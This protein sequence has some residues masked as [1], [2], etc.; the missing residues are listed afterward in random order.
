M[1]KRASAKFQAP[2]VKLYMNEDM[3]VIDSELTLLPQGPRTETDADGNFELHH[4]IRE[5]FIIVPRAKRE[6]GHEVEHYQWA[7]PSAKIGADGKLLLSNS[8]MQE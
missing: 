5:P 6:V 1:A 2:L 8:N 7:V 3:S 4:T